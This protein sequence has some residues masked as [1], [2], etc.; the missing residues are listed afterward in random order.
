M[1]TFGKH[2]G[3][4]LWQVLRESPSYVNWCAETIPRFR[5]MLERDY[6]DLVL[7]LIA[8]RTILEAAL[9]A[10]GW[11]GGRM[12]SFDWAWERVLARERK[13]SIKNRIR[14]QS[15]IGGP[16]GYED[17]EYKDAGAGI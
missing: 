1:F 2:K 16:D 9:D 7:R 15:L 11:S 4:P 17:E 10:W 14:L 5:L 6:R 12:P 3:K 13:S 8:A